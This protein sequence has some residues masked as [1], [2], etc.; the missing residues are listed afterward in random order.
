VVERTI[1][2]LIVFLQIVPKIAIAPLF[3]IWFGFGFTPKLLLV[4]LLSFFP[5]VVAAIAG[6]KSID[7]ETMELA[8]STGASE[9][10]IFRKIRLPH[11]MPSIFTGL[12][13]AAALSSTAA[14][15]AEFVASDKGLGYL[16]LQYNGD[17]ET[18]MVFATI[19]VLSVVGLIVYYLVELIEKLAIPWHVSQ[20]GEGGGMTMI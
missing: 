6:F 7:E 9:W 11:A 18:P 13:V 14:V 17:L 12:K 8:R 1:Y 2:P 19:I 10:M 3:I 4:F 20:R 5:I 15:V 16:L